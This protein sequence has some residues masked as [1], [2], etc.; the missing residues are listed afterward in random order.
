MHHTGI[1]EHL[2][3]ELQVQ[4]LDCVIIVLKILVTLDFLRSMQV[5]KVICLP[6]LFNILYCIHV[7]SENTDIYTHIYIYIYIYTTHT[8]IYIYIRE[9]D[10]EGGR[11]RREWRE[12][13]SS[14]GLF[15]LHH[16]MHTYTI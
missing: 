5:R 10:R 13:L 9:I 1:I 8:H 3:L 6:G 14:G 12:M 4:L 11:D 15:T 16:K 2:F 7:W